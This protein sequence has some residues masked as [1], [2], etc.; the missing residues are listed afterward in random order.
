MASPP[1]LVDSLDPLFDMEGDRC[2]SNRNPRTKLGF[3]SKPNAQIEVIADDAEGDDE[4]KDDDEEEIPTGIPTRNTP[5]FPLAFRIVP[6]SVCTVDTITRL[7]REYQVPDAL[8][9]ALP[10]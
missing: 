7:R 10:P 2:R 6:N 1:N 5:T 8:T 3:V 9:L 4:D